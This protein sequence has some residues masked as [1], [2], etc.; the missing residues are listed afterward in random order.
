MLTHQQTFAENIGLIIFD[1][2]HQFDTGER[3]VTYELLLTELK[4]FLPEG[5]QKILISAVIHNAQQISEW[6]SPS[7]KVIQGTNTLPTERS[8]GIV[9]FDYGIGQ[10]NF[11]D[12]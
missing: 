3:G 11:V 4:R 6:L 7:N 10:I 1:E 2:G 5:C 8:I 9:N 12:K